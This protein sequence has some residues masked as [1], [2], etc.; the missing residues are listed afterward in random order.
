MKRYGKVYQYNKLTA[1]TAIFEPS[2][3]E[4]RVLVIHLSHS[5]DPRN[6]EA[7]AGIERRNQLTQLKTQL[8][9]MDRALGVAVESFQDLTS[10][11]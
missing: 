5:D 6:E 9:L 2:E 4:E 3:R 10:S 7:R 1:Q 8:Q 11:S